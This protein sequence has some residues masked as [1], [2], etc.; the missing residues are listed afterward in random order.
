M[1]GQPQLRRSVAWSADERDSRRRQH[2]ADRR[3]SGDLLRAVHRALR[4]RPRDHDV[5][6]CR[7][8][9]EPVPVVR[10]RQSQ[11]FDR[12]EKP[13]LH[14]R[15]IL[16]AVM[17]ATLPRAR[18]ARV[19]KSKGILG[20]LTTVDHKKSAIMDLFLTFF[21]FIAGGIMALWNRIKLA[22]PQ[23]TFLTA[24]QYN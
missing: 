16:M 3:S 6:C 1:R 12:R 21:F 15:R 7:A 20:W 8:A 10:V 11:R 18:F 24:E 17:D 19:D 5:R 14:S 2:G 9:H 4:C 23:N 22:E 13:G